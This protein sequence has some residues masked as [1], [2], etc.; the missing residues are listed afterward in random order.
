MLPSTNHITA[1]VSLQ[2]EEKNLEGT[3]VPAFPWKRTLFNLLN[4]IFNLPHRKLGSHNPVSGSI[5][6]YRMMHL[7][8]I[9][10]SMVSSSH[11]EHLKL[12]KMKLLVDCWLALWMT[13]NNM[14]VWELFTRYFVRHVLLNRV[15]QN[16]SGEGNWMKHSSESE[17]PPSDETAR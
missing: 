9:W 6:F 3:Q 11:R 12:R 17:P 5:S 7:L 10:P 1:A 13:H 15:R 8:Q 2:R 4:I 14:T 16:G